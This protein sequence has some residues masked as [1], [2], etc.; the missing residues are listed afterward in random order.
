MGLFSIRNNTHLH[1]CLRFSIH[2]AHYRFDSKA[3]GL[4]TFSYELYYPYDG[5][6]GTLSSKING[7]D[8]E[9]EYNLF[10]LCRYLKLVKNQRII[11]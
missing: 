3:I 7:N 2:I 6:N 1:V 5:E 9:L 10:I 11:E 8:N 4:Y